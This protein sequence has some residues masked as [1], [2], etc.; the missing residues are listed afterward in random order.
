MRKTRQQL[1]DERDMLLK[2]NKRKHKDALKNRYVKKFRALYGNKFEY[3]DDDFYSKDGRISVICPIHGLFKSTIQ[4]LLSGCGCP[5]CNHIVQEK[6]KLINK[7]LSVFNKG[8]PSKGEVTISSFLDKN[9]IKYCC[10][11]RLPNEYLFNRREYMLADFYLPEH[12]TIIE[13]NGQQHYYH[14]KW[15][16]DENVFRMQQERDYGLRLYCKEHG[17]KLIEISYKDESKIVDI[18]KTKVKNLNI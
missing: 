10:E 3:P 6:S 13:Y 15:F 18:L 9:G 5:Y 14:V 16:G 7:G 8:V 1:I 11:Y 4:S 17:I 12:N 2:Q